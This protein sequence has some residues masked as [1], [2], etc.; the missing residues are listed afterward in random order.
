MPRMG[1]EEPP[2]GGGGGGGDFIRHIRLLDNRES[3][4]LR[5]LTEYGDFYWEKFHRTFDGKG[6]FTGMKLCVKSALGQACEPCDGNDRPGTQ[7][8]GWAYEFYHDYPDKPSHVKSEDLEEVEVGKR[9]VFREEVNAPRLMR[10]S[11]MHFDPITYQYDEEDTVTDRNFKWARQGEKGST[12]PTYI[13]KPGKPEKLP[14]ELKELAA[15]LPDLEDVAFGKIETLGGE[16]KEEAEAD[17]GTRKIGKKS[18]KAK[19]DEPVDSD[20]I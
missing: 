15:T 6:K 10:Y 4:V 7:Y 9:T 5:F 14:K 2:T 17:A 16:K 1:D 19:D 12:R 11:I 8:L 13:L 3:C 20:D 18:K